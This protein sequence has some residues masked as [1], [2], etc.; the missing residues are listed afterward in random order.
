MQPLRP[1]TRL[2]GMR[3]IQISDNGEGK[4]DEVVRRGLSQSLSFPLLDFSSLCVLA[5]G[6]CVSRLSAF[7]ES[8]PLA[9]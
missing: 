6:M 3:K 4:D 1:Q 2:C 8:L 9:H 7:G 5:L